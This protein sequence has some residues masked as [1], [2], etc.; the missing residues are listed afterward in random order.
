MA[1][2]RLRRLAYI[3]LIALA[4]ACS[5]GDKNPADSVDSGEQ[6]EQA[7]TY[8]LDFTKA[9]K[10]PDLYFENRLLPFTDDMERDYPEEY[11][12]L[13]GGNDYSGKIRVGLFG[14]VPISKVA[15][16]Q[17]MRVPFSPLEV[18]SLINAGQLSPGI[19]R[20][21]EGSSVVVWFFETESNGKRFV[22]LR[23][24]ASTLP[25]KYGFAPRKV[26]VN[27]VQ[28]PL[29]EQSP[30]SLHESKTSV[31]ISHYVRPGINALEYCAADGNEQITDLF[32]N[33][34]VISSYEPFSDNK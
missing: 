2:R 1:K 3:P 26:F 28:V 23:D 16:D 6:P 21:G 9:F 27:G 17:G 19:F 31:D 11:A 33:E 25:D 34:I 15:R 30:E 12:N 14:V 18:I 32:L 5:K 20:N 10:N 8:D 7:V 29:S 22:G 13:V 24:L 4:A